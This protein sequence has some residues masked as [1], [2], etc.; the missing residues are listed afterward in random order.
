MEQQDLAMDR[1]RG[2][3]LDLQP[4]FLKIVV[5]EFEFQVRFIILRHYLGEAM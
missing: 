3:N 1:Q 4:V 5:D 2:Y